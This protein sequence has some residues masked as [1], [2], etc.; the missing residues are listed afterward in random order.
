M[1]NKSSEQELDDAQHATSLTLSRMPTGSTASLDI[2]SILST[3]CTKPLIT[4]CK[5]ESPNDHSTQ[6]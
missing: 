3:R 1:Q 2:P 6:Q 5:A 4:L